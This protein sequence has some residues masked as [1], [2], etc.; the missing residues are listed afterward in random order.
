MKGKLFHLGAVNEGIKH[1]NPAANYSQHFTDSSHNGIA[2]TLF[3]ILMTMVMSP[4]YLSFQLAFL[5]SHPFD[6]L[7]T[8][9][10]PLCSTFAL[11]EIGPAHWQAFS[12]S[13]Y[14]TDQSSLLELYRRP[15]LLGT[16]HPFLLAK[17]PLHASRLLA[18]IACVSISTVLPISHPDQKSHPVISNLVPLES[19]WK[20]HRIELQRQG[21]SC[22]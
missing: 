3:H 5:E 11:L 2:A 13:L 10:E 20:P 4:R 6:E 19:S 17:R 12:R 22:R 14:E 18:L 15:S 8:F 7:N 21:I 1:C 16:S 9:L